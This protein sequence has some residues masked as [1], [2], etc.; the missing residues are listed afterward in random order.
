MNRERVRDRV[1]EVR[2]HR[3]CSAD[4]HEQPEMMTR[5]A[6]TDVVELHSGTITKLPF[7]ATLGYFSPGC[8]QGDEAVFT[9]L[10]D[11]AAKSDKT[12]L[13]TVDAATG[14][15]QTKATVPG[16]V[17]SA[18]PVSG[19]I[20]AARGHHI[21]EVNGGRVREIATTK[22]TPFQLKAD[23]DGGVMSIDRPPQRQSCPRG[24]GCHRD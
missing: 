11:G 12:R 15:V 23:D 6:F 21:V 8:G 5:S 2:R 19:G 20:A 13:V 24:G 7:Q 10:T 3:L 9:A 14:K 16:Q 22:S 4:V 17:T 18:I 1:R